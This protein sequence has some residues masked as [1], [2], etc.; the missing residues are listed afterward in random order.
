MGA[1]LSSRMFLGSPQVLR[2]LKSL[3]MHRCLLPFLGICWSKYLVNAAVHFG[4]ERDGLR[5]KGG[6][7]ENQ[8]YE[9]HNLTMTSEIKVFDNVNVC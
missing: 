8:N 9:C 7:S 2:A 4:R 3:K 1:V 5:E 6:L